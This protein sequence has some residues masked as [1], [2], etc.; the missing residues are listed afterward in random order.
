M[1]DE[2][3]FSLSAKV[4]SGALV[5]AIFAIGSRVLGLVRDR[6]LATTFGAGDTLDAYF[7]AFKIPD[8]IFNIL[9]LGGLASAFIPVFI[10]LK[11][12]KSLEEAWKVATTVFNALVVLL[13]ILAVL[14]IIF[15]SSLVPMIAPGFSGDKL[16]LTIKLS[17]IMMLAIV[18]FGASNVLSGILQSFRRFLFYSLAP[19]MYNLGI[20]LGIILIV[21]SAGAVGLGFG[22]FLGSIMHMLIQLPTVLKLGWRWHL[23]FNIFHQSVKKIVKLILPRTFGLA[24]HSFNQIVLTIFA[25]TLVA[26]S[27]ASFTL[28]LNLQSF[29]INVFGVSLAIAAFPLFSEAWANN[30]P[31]E[32][33]SHLSDSI[34]RVLFFVIPLSI[35][36]LIL[37]AQIVRV[38]LGAG[39]F[40]WH[41]TFMTAQVLGF[42]ALSLIAESLLPLIARAF[43]ALQDTRT[44]VIVSSVAL[45]INIILSIILI[46][47]FGLL[48]LALAYVVAGI[49]NFSVLIF[50]LGERL[51]SL[52]SKSVIQASMRILLAAVPA[53]LIT[54]G[55]LQVIAPLVDMYTF[56]GIF[57]QGVGAG[58][59][60]VLT[61]WLFAW[62]LKLPEV[63]FVNQWLH[64]AWA[65]IK[66]YGFSQN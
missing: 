37:R 45:V 4:T 56:L 12:K 30:K 47:P 43:Y 38:V 17:R 2:K 64:L 11:N 34:R 14:G 58:M 23:K 54:Y 55:A 29:P 59:L 28:A 18:F 41:D 36:F 44:P 51:G 5:I 16:E 63:V 31:S 48:G 52:Q 35:L 7:A 15:A 13:L 65:K 32:L 6:L 62:V 42:L 57:I 61:Y 22:V 19:V 60:G 39:A 1:S 3:N 49:I 66:Q 26:G 20:I 40:D 53:G 21:P 25:S 50:I 10:E 9:V 24:V 46:K 33:V 27:L 8:F